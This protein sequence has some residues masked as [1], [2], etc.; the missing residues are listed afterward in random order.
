M[1]PMQQDEYRENERMIL[2]CQCGTPIPP[3][4]ANTCVNC[5]RAQVDITAEI[6]KQIN[7]NWCK[8]CDRYLQP[9]NTWM[10]CQLESR[11]LLALLL[12][13]LKGL[14]Q[15]RL[16]DASFLW[17]EPHSRRIRVKLTI[18]KEV[19]TST[20]LQQTFQV[21]AVVAPMMCN[22]CQRQMAQNTWTAVV[23]ARQKV[24]HKKTFL[25]LEQLILKHQAHQN[26]LNIK[27]SKDGLDFFFAQ[28]Q[29]AVQFLQFLQSCVPLRTQNSQQLMSTD[30]KNGTAQYRFT[31]TAEIV[32]ICKN[33]LVVLPLN[34]ARQLG[35]INPLVLC[36]RISGSLVQLLD[37]RT[38]KSA[39]LSGN[40]Y[41]RQPFTALMEAGASGSSRMSEFY[42]LEVEP[43][44]QTSTNG[45]MQLADVT[46]AKCMRTT[47]EKKSLTEDDLDID[48][49]TT[50]ITRTHL[51]GYLKEGDYVQGYDLSNVNFNSDL[52]DAY[53]QATQSSSAYHQMPDVVL[54]KRIHFGSKSKGRV[55]KLKRLARE[56]AESMMSTDDGRDD[57]FEGFMQDLE[58]DK[59]M[60]DMVHLFKNPRAPQEQILKAQK[61]EGEV[62]L[63][64]LMDELE[65][66]AQP[67]QM[68]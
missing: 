41:W 37:V 36:Q 63:A 46:V 5:I 65:I 17:T 34:L 6:P 47:K 19:F 1:D 67:D 66:D 39:D 13:K 30:I 45:R 22:A 61:G 15:V 57:D 27:E 35:N 24:S 9:P 4:P 49:S 59:D 28:K 58:A 56:K 53:Y 26:C 62:D 50:Y 8:N 43:L 10:S 29:H 32:P 25:F 44:N 33:D 7:V 52:F 38:M 42:V 3:N 16:I 11:E 40:V 2:C 20:I 23:Q 51:G 48:M 14:S 12:K 18:Q 68:S 60:R 64:E 54:V 55:F 31:F 21:E